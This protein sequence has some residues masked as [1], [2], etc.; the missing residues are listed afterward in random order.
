MLEL[1]EEAGEE[2]EDGDGAVAA[3]W[4][5]GSSGSA[6]LEGAEASTGEAADAASV[7][8]VYMLQA[9]EFRRV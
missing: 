2:I 7:R 1:I 4:G 5:R 8:N 3:A 9:S 6:G